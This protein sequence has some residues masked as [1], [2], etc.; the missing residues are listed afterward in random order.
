MSIPYT[1]QGDYIS[2]IYDIKI[3]AD[4]AKKQITMVWIYF[5]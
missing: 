2:D 5:F 3:I 1:I 4:T